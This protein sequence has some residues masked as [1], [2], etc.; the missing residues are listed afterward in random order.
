MADHG[1][2]DRLRVRNL[3]IDDVALVNG[4]WASQTPADC[5]RMSLDPSKIPT[6]FLRPELIERMLR[7]PVRER[8]ADTLIWELNARAIGMSSLRNIRYGEYGEIHLHVIDPTSRR[9]GY[10]HRF[11]ALSLQEY[12][13][14]FALELIVCEPSS[15]N[16]GPNRLLQKLGFTVAKTYRTVPSDINIEHEVNRYEITRVQGLSASVS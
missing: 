4:Y 7:V 6:R 8:A 3:C 1:A 13:R 14:R 2:R 16:P 15:R 5:E 12:F 9:S 10:G 11:F